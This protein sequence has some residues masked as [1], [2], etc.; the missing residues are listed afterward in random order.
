MV[1]QTKVSFL[2]TGKWNIKL[3]C[4][5]DPAVEDKHVNFL[6]KGGGHHLFVIGKCMRPR[7]ARS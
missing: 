6:N 3:L 4:G 2:E 7:E 1:T 5:P